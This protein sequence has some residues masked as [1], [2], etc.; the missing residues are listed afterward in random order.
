[1]LKKLL[2]AAV[3]VVAGMVV[4][5]KVTKISPMV[6]FGDCCRSARNM[7]P[8]EMQLKQLKAD[9]DN[10]DKDIDKNLASLARKSA[11]VDGF[12][13]NLDRD[14]DEQA[15][16]RADIRDMQKSLKD[17]DEKVVYRGNKTDADD[18]TRR[19]DMAVTKF[20]CLKEKVKT[21]EKILAE[22]KL[23]LNTAKARISEMKNEQEKLRLL[24]VKLE[25]HLELVKM[26]QIQNQ[27]TDFDNSALSRAQ[28][29]AKGVETRLR[30]IEK[31]IEYKKEFGRTDTVNVE[32]EKGKSR[33]EVLHNAKAALQD[34]KT[35][36]VAIDKNEK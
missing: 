11:D 16:L 14:R 18:L 19:L 26:K 21:Q 9:I 15:H 3:A 36:E 25:H 8:P 30:E 5:T 22:K 29:N 7:V 23:A 6:L 1:M 34:D 4:L 27:V 12:A 17:G 24:A 31:L 28:E 33:E 32:M 10:I 13:D 20:T 35:D 2:I